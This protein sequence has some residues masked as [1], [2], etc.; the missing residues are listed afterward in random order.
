MGIDSSINHEL[1]LVVLYFFMYSSKIFAPWMRSWFMQVTA[2]FV[3][4]IQLT[5][6]STLPRSHTYCRNLPNSLM[7]SS[8]TGTFEVQPNSLFFLGLTRLYSVDALMKLSL[9]RKLGPH[10]FI[11]SIK[12]LLS[13]VFLCWVSPFLPSLFLWYISHHF[14]F[15]CC[16]SFGC[17]PI[18][19]CH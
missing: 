6:N 11:S 19:C 5:H 15:D 4:S 12:T 7:V 18:S 1:S 3:C 13:S 8:L 16:G 10:L 2:I 9:S 17:F 14:L